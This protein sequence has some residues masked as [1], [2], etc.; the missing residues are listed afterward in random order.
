MKDYVCGRTMNYKTSL[1]L[2]CG[3]VAKMLPTKAYGFQD[4][5]NKLYY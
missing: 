4:P 5:L 1:R 3:Y 2:V